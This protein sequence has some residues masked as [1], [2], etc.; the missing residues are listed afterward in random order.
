SNPPKIDD[1]TW[2]VLGTLLGG[3]LASGAARARVSAA[4]PRQ[5]HEPYRRAGLASIAAEPSGGP[6]LAPSVAKSVAGGALVMLGARIAEGCTSGHGL[7]G[8]A[9]AGCA[10][11]AWSRRSPSRSSRW[12]CS[13]GRRSSEQEWPCPAIA[14]APLRRRRVPA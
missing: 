9:H 10:A 12:R 5:A 2:F 1:E 14:P 6:G 7:S 11:V 3:V 13:A 8:T 4:A